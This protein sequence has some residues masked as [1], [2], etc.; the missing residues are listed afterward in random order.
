MGSEGS[1][2]GLREALS[3]GLPEVSEVLPALLLIL[4]LTLRCFALRHLSGRR[5]DL[6]WFGILGSGFRYMVSDFGI[7]RYMVS[8]FGV[9]GLRIR[10]SSFEGLGF[11]VSS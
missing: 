5:G 4:A 6:A 2:K 11:R 10:V 3:S 1:S 9:S 8:G 7:F